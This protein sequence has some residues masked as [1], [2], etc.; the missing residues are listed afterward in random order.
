MVLASHEDLGARNVVLRWKPELLFTENESNAQRL[1]GQ[2]NPSPHVKDAFH[3][4]VVTGDRR[5]QSVADRYEGGRTLPPE[6][7]G[8][9]RRGDPAAAV[10]DPPARPFSLDRDVFHVPG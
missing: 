4:F 7:G 8:R 1:W 9:R 6:G 5:A 10:H 2:P 3:T